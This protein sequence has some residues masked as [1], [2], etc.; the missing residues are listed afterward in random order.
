MRIE[1]EIITLFYDME[2]HYITILDM[3]NLRSQHTRCRHI[4]ALF[5]I[6]VF[7]GVKNCPPVLET[8]G[9]RVPSRNICNFSLFCCPSSY[10]PS[11][12]CVSAANRVCDSLDIFRNSNISLK[13]SLFK[14][15]L[16]WQSIFQDTSYDFIIDI[17]NIC[18]TF[19][20][21]S[22]LIYGLF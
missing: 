14:L 2:Y 8:V 17:F 15:F 19:G 22:I 18:R 7:K 21:Y 16:W 1:I 11:A 12:S 10:C 5:L 20:K 3:L 4:D 9:I 6:C 13:F